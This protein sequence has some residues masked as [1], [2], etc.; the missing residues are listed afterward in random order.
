M[1]LEIKFEPRDLWVGIFWDF[2]DI[3]VGFYETGYKILKVY[4]C[5]VPMF[6]I[7]FTVT[8]RI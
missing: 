6:P 3:P 8:R 1:K 2:N 5:L 7:I 4:L